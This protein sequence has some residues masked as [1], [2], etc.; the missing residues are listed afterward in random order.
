M[1]MTVQHAANEAANRL[2]AA[3]ILHTDL[4][5]RHVGIAPVIDG[6]GEVTDVLPVLIDFDRCEIG[7][8]CANALQQM[9]ERLMEMSLGVLFN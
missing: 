2:A 8:D 3:G 9:Q 6:S 1:G 5:W 4:E 7:V